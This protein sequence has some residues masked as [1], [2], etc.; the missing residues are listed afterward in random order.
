MVAAASAEAERCVQALTDAGAFESVILRPPL[1]YGPGQSGNLLRMMRWV[2]AGRPLPVAGVN[3][4]RSLIYVG[5]LA[6]ALTERGC[7]VVGVNA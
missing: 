2:A 4:L 5:N 7:K 1:I 3:N 6:D